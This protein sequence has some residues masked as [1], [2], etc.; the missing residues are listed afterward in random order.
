MGRIKMRTLTKWLVI[1]LLMAPGLAAQTKESL[2]IGPGDL[3]HVL[4]F[5]SPEL[6]E[7]ARVTDAGELPLIL[8]GSVKVASLTLEQASRVVEATLKDGHFILNPRVLITFDESV[9]LKVAVLGEVKVPGMFATQTPRSILE[10]LSMAGGVTDTADRRI[11]IERH[12]SSEKVPYTIS[13]AP[14][15]ALD[16]A[17]MVYPGD[18]V[19]VPKAGIV[20]ALGDVGHPGGY[21]MT[22]NDSQT[23]VLE[24]IARAGGTNHT[25]VPSHARLIRKSANGYVDIQLPL[26][27]MEKGKKADLQ[28]QADDIV[29]VPF[30]YL[31]NLAV[32]AAGIAAS[33]SSAAVYRF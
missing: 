5:D 12:G 10:V 32:N 23:S 31:L 24:L 22:N 25:A 26:G 6:E 29:Y 20:Y 16:S 11:V 9:G 3:L 28:L 30:S 27:E 21:A 19:F 13:N 4:V 8:G 2:L 15:A 14:N 33:A 1:S 18:K 7:H 17:V